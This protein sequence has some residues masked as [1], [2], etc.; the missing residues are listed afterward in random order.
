MLSTEHHLVLVLYIVF[1]YCLI[2]YVHAHV[3][4]K[5]IVFVFYWHI[6]RQSDYLLT[7]C[8]MRQPTEYINCARQGILNKTISQVTVRCVCMY[9]CIPY[10]GF[11]SRVENFTNCANCNPEE[12]LANLNFARVW[13]RMKHVISQSNHTRWCTIGLRKRKARNL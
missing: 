7:P 6:Q 4:Q 3:Q 12:N 11:I 10:S 5:K 9:V 8:Y 2:E 1:L 13:L